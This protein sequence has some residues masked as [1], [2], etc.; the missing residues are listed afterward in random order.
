MK[1]L[2]KLVYLKNV[3]LLPENGLL[4]KFDNLPIWRNN[5]LNIYFTDRHHDYYECVSIY[6][7][8]NVLNYYMIFKNLAG[9]QLYIEISNQLLNVWYAEYFDHIEDRNTVDYLEEIEVLNFRSEKMEKTIQDWKDEYINLETT[10][11]DLL[12][13]SK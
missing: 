4:L 13:G 8:K 9:E 12:R 5:H 6:F 10:Y 1:I 2:N 11:L 3:E 7:K